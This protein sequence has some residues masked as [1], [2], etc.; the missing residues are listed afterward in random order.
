MIRHSLP[1]EQPCVSQLWSRDSPPPTPVQP[2]EL[3]QNV[4]AL[5]QNIC[6][7]K[8]NLTGTFR[9]TAKSTYIL[10]VILSICQIASS[11]RCVLKH[12]RNRVVIIFCSHKH[13]ITHF[14]Q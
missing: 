2:H 14:V 7:V 11:L 6:Y 8:I 12:L 9:N 10:N 1:R 4:A 5:H 13:V 3:T